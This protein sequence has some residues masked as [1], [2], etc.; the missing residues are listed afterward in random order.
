MT[1]TVPPLDPRVA[2]AALARRLTY[3]ECLRLMR[4]AQQAG[5]PL[6]PVRFDSSQRPLVLPT[7][8]ELRKFRGERD[9]LRHYAKLGVGPRVHRGIG[10]CG[11][12]EAVCAGRLSAAL[13]V[14]YDQALDLIRRL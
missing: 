10:S 3:R 6:P 4:S 5:R 7:A 14:E 13:G 12:D 1:T 11:A 8:R 9:A 2:K